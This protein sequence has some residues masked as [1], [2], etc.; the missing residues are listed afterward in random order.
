MRPLPPSVYAGALCI[1]DIAATPNDVHHELNIVSHD[2]HHEP[3][4]SAA[5][6]CVAAGRQKCAC[7]PCK[8]Q[9]AAPPASI[10]HRVQSS[11]A[12]C[13]PC[14]ARHVPNPAGRAGRGQG[15]GPDLLQ[16]FKR[17]RV[18]RALHEPGQHVWIQNPEKRMSPGS[19]WPHLT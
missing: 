8:P 12:A 4:P 5:D 9:V 1:A 18:R 19:P 17:G 15:L 7:R 11:C 16:R 13:Q 14:Q 10:T 3:R 2:M 6:A